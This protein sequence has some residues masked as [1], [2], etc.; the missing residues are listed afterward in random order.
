M[1]AHHEIHD[2]A[3]VRD[4][5]LDH[6]ELVA[7]QPRDMIGI[8]DAA[9]DPPGHGLQ[10]FVADMMSERI[11]DALEFV[12]VDIEQCELSA[13][14]GSLQLAFDAFAEQHPVRQVGQR[15]VMREMGD[16][17]VGEAALGDVFDDVDD[18]ARLAGLI[19]D[20]DALRGDQAVARYLAFPRVLVADQTVGALQGH[21]IVPGD[22]IGRFFREQID[23]RLADDIIVRHAELSL[24]YPVGQHIAAIAHVLHGNLRRDVVDD[25]AQEC[26]VAV[27]LLFDMPTLRDVFDRG[28]PSA[29][30]QRL[31]DD[32]KRASVGTFHDAAGDLSGSDVLHDG[33][34]E[35]QDVAV[36][37]SGILAMLDQ[38]EEV[39]PRLHDLGRQIV[40][41]EVALV[42]GDDPCGGVIQHE[43]LRHVVQRGVEP[44]LLRFQP[45]LRFPI[46]PGHLPDDHE[47]NEGDH[48]CGQSGGRDQKSGLLAPVGQHRRDGR[49]RDHHD[50][51]AA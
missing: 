4:V 20:S 9:P 23:S 51:K 10:Q 11:V 26:G 14:A 39:T 45:V 34:A 41:V 42:G 49:G 27:A 29:L 15:I 12:D 44:M 19:P 35:F 2:V 17:L 46:L 40:H 37:R 13:A 21:F 3:R 38:V 48:Q 6:R 1:N 22:D 36:E 30:R 24:G 7:A 32:L 50:R 33:G 43:T 28:D 8:A 18:V 5:G 16:L 31:V 47:Q 25:L